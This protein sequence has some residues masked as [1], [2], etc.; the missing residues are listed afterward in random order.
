MEVFQSSAIIPATLCAVEM[1]VKDLSEL[2][3]FTVGLKHKL[4]CSLY[5]LKD[6][7]C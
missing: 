2:G 6:F 7:G 4:E 5:G 1:E 3:K